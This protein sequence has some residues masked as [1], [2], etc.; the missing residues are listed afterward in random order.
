MF[1]PE[2][3][4]QPP[5]FIPYPATDNLRI[6]EAKINSLSDQVE[7]YKPTLVSSNKSGKQVNLLKRRIIGKEIGKN[8]S[9][10]CIT[11]LENIADQIEIL[12]KEIPEI[13]FYMTNSDK[14]NV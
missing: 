11:E 6:M 2:E 5:F 12:N 7:T 13:L 9:S 14:K 4:Y 8:A 3:Y 10:K 1:F